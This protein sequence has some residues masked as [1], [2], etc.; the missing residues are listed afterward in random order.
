VRHSLRRL[1]RDWR[2]TTAAVL[3]LGLGI[4]ASTAVFSI[5]NAVLFRHTPLPAPDR[6]VDIYQ[7]SADPGG[8]DFNT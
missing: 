3:I 7:R 4:G 1:L 6:L 8:Q 2:F 5:I